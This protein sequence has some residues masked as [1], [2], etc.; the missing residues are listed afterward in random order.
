MNITIQLKA[1]EES[2]E[3]QFQN[4]ELLIQ[5]LTH[6]SYANEQK[7]VKSKNYERIEFLGDAVLELV[8]SEF[9]YEKYPD[10]LEG[11]LTKKRAMAV[12]EMALADVAKEIYLGDYLLLGKGEESTGGRNRDSI[13]ADCIEAI[14]GAIY[15][16]S[17]LDQ[18]KK[19]IH[20]FILSDFEKKQLFYDAKS[21]LQELV[22]RNKDGDL[23]YALVEE[24][25]PDHEKTFV[26]QVIV[27]GEVIGVGYGKSKKMSEQSA[28]YDALLKMQNKYSE[29]V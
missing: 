14:I 13:I 20:R 11:Q 15:L 7:L 8:S 18:A 17:G 16:D 28:A 19:F 27:K 22:Q 1:F 25:G 21:T 23:N 2:I 12:C 29:Q 4:R 3:Y 9:L 6:S 24:S 10:M 5:A 26:T